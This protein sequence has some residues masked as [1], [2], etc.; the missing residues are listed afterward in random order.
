MLNF[1]NDPSPGIVPELSIFSMKDG[2]GNQE[3]P[4]AFVKSE[5]FTN[6]QGY[7]Q[8]GKLENYLLYPHNS[9][10]RCL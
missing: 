9:Y 4:E 3:F 7:R 6:G 10:Q 1:V 8:D 5:L 2:S